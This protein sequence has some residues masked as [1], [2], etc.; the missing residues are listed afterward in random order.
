MK[1]ETRVFE[2]SKGRYAHLSELAQAM[3]VSESHVSRVRAGKRGINETFIIGA[4][5]AF[6]G[7]KLDELFHVAPEGARMTSENRNELGRILKQRRV[8]I[9]L[10]LRELGTMSGVSESY[11]GRI[12]RGERFP[13]ANILHKM[14]KPLG[15]G[16]SE[17][18]ALAGLL[19][20]EPSSGIESEAQL[21]R[22]DPYVARVLADEPV[23]VQRAVIAILTG[24]RNIATSL[25]KK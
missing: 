21:G 2:L 10:T 8:I 13:S 20:L 11:L 1:L 7:Y 24:L 19:S 4:K 9:P 25:S 12:E 3:G 6:S 17:L 22:L 14:A 15:L 18:L 16:E 23:E 5:R